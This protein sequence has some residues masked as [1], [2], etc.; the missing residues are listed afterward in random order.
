MFLFIKSDFTELLKHDPQ[1]VEAKKELAQVNGAIKAFQQ[2]EKKLFG[3][4]FS[5]GG[6]YD[7]VKPTPAPPKV[8]NE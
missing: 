1:N 2:K 4:M 8:D 3:H 7:D 6:L 5:K